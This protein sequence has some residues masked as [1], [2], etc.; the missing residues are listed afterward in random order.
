MNQ[1]PALTS[2]EILPWFN[3]QEMVLAC[4]QQV[5]KDL[6]M[7]GIKLHFNGQVETAYQELFSQLQPELEQLL[8]KTSSLS[9]ILYRVDVS[10]EQVKKV[11]LEEEPYSYALARLILWR[12]LQ[13]VVTRFILS[14]T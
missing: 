2:Q 10:E 4:V 14:R 3:K 5:Q 13:K 1:P 6:G 12:E 7:F 11:M 9:Q 8:F